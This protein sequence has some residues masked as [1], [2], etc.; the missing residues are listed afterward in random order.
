LVGD[1]GTAHMPNASWLVRIPSLSHRPL[2]AANTD[3]E[4]CSHEEPWAAVCSDLVDRPQCFVRYALSDALLLAVA[5]LSD[6][7]PAS[8]AEAMGITDS[9]NIADYSSAVAIFDTLLSGLHAG[10]AKDP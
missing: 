1:R 5:F 7:F 8:L 6:A 10:F 4:A 3:G 9:D 2:M